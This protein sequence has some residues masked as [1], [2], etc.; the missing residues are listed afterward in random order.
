MQQRICIVQSNSMHSV[1]WM[2]LLLLLAQLL[3]VDV[4]PVCSNIFC[5]EEGCSTCDQQV[6]SC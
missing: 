3:L 2:T 4:E 6:I 1:H 5:L